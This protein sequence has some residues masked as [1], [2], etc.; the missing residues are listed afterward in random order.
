M[1]CCAGIVIC[2]EQG[3]NDLHIVQLM[4]LPPYHLFIKIQLCQLN[5]VVLKQRPLNGSFK[6]ESI[7]P[8]NVVVLS[9]YICLSALML[10]VG[11][12]EGHSA[13]KKLWWG[14]SM[15]IFLGRGA[16]LHM[17]QL[18]PLPLTVSC[19]C[20]SQLVLLFWY[21][22]TQVVLDKGP[23]KGCMY[24]CTGWPKKSKPL[25]HLR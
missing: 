2:L 24:V 18:I 13:C 5:K 8:S 1:A 12:Q 21:H 16:D 10:L 6:G 23:L 19:S 20:I 9:Q 17:A 7:I 25:P 4:P 3:T 22:L 14:A 11:R 15:V